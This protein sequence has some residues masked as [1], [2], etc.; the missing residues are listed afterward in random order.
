MMP[1]NSVEDDG[2]ASLSPEGKTNRFSSTSQASKN[3]QIH[4]PSF[5][6]LPKTQSR[7]KQIMLLNIPFQ[8]S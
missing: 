2:L 4:E 8:T 3:L 5:L 6:K 7:S 1:K